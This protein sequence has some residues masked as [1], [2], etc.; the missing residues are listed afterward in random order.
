MIV[1]Q[2]DNLDYRDDPMCQWAA[3]VIREQQA[4]I[5]Q[6]TAIVDKLPKTADGVPIVPWPPTVVY[7]R[8]TY[9]GRPEIQ[10][11]KGFAWGAAT[12]DAIGDGEPSC[13]HVGRNVALCYSTREAAAEANP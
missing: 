12:F 6:L 10:A 3:K 1:Y 9:H 13:G 4:E 2:V 7:R 8:I 5:E 11:S